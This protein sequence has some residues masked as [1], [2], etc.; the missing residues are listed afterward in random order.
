MITEQE[1]KILKNLVI[2]DFPSWKSYYAMGEKKWDGW[3]P[4]NIEDVFRCIGK[5]FRSIEEIQV[6]TNHLNLEG[7]CS[8][9][10]FT[11]GFL[12]GCIFISWSFDSVTSKQWI[13]IDEER[14]KTPLTIGDIKKYSYLYSEIDCIE[15]LRMYK[16]YKLWQ[17]KDKEIT[18]TTQTI[19]LAQ[20]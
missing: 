1:Y 6:E 3:K 13:L 4:N 5:K 19:N 10:G 12:D 11:A 17:K 20:E 18:I 16:I 2:S 9:G 8:S 7:W 14:I 15:F